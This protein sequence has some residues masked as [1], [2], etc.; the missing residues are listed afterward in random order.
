LFSSGRHVELGITGAFG[1]Q[2]WKYQVQGCFIF[3]GKCQNILVSLTAQ[4]E[5]G[6]ASC[7]VDFPF[8]TD[9]IFTVVNSHPMMA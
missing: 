1:M 6:R 4:S 2:E 8:L 7:R 9:K 3:V 5:F